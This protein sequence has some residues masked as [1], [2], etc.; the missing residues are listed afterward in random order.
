VRILLDQNVPFPLLKHLTGH[1]VTHAYD[2]GWGEL[3]NGAL[4]AGAEANGFELLIT[5]DQNLEYQNNLMG[6]SLALIVLSTNTWSI[7]RMHLPA[8]VAEVRKAAV[9]SYGFVQCQRPPL[10]RRPPTV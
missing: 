5:A 6:R 7:I 1:D 4:I 9:G 10:Q 2:V 3:E 8:I